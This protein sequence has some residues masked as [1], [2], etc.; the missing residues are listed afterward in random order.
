MKTHLQLSKPGCGAYRRNR[1]IR[2]DGNRFHGRPAGGDHRLSSS[3]QDA[4]VVAVHGGSCAL[5]LGCPP[6]ATT[7]RIRPC[8]CILTAAGPRLGFPRWQH[9]V[10]HQ[11][12]HKLGSLQS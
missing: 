10:H 2:R 3:S 1:S 7:C 12:P 6:L 4:G 11:S 9:G 5:G 8:A